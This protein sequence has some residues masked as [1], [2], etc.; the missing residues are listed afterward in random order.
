MLLAATCWL[1][2]GSWMVQLQQPQQHRAIAQ[3]RPRPLQQQMCVYLLRVER[4]HG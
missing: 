1:S 3:L 4:N 2:F